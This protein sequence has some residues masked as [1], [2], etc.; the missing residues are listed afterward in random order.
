MEGKNSMSGN[1]ILLHILFGDSFNSQ[2][3]RKR[4]FQI[5]M[6]N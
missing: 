3:I 2:V 6:K 5:Q 1:F 4:K